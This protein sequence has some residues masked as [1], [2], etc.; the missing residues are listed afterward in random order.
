MTDSQGVSLNIYN[1]WVSSFFRIPESIGGS[2][3]DCR[4]LLFYIL[5]SFFSYSISDERYTVDIT[6][7]ANYK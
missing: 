5:I 1:P 2:R 3:D 6:K 4:L 7:V